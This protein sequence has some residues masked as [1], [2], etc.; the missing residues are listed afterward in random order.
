MRTPPLDRELLA[1]EVRYACGRGL[2]VQE[3]EDLVF[4]AIQRVRERFDPA[5]GAFATLLR[6]AVRNA[7]AGWWRRRART[8]RVHADLAHLPPPDRE[9]ARRAQRNQARLFEALDDEEQRIFSAWALQKHLG[10]GRVTS[11]DIGASLGMDV[12]TYENAKRR[13]KGR[14]RRLLQERGWTVADVLYGESDV[15]R[16]G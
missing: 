12:V 7:C 11:T 9:R 5:R 8:D 13:L 1:R 2:P 16:T 6:A 15:E 14:L 10:K 4:E 3:A